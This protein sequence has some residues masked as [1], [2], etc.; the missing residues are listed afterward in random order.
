MNQFKTFL[1]LTAMTLILIYV[2]SLIGG[3]N[4]M[5]I[6]LGIAIV[7]NF[8][9]FF[10]SDKIVLAMY[11]ARPVD[12]NDNYILPIVRNLTNSANLPMPKVYII[13]EASPNAFATGR[14][15]HHAA[16]AVTT[17]ILNLLSK[18]ELEGVIAHELSHVK[19]RDILVSS[20][21]A[22]LVGTISII[23]RIAFFFGGGRDD[24]NGAGCIGNLIFI[25]LSSI[26]MFLIQMWISRTREYMADE[27]G[28]K[29]CGKP[30]ALASALDRLRTG[31]AARP[32][33][34]ANPVTQNMFIVNPLNA[35]SIA[36]LMS[37]HPPLQDRINRLNAMNMHQN[38]FIR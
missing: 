36:T 38:S 32:M 22:V 13:N 2:G 3:K 6:G 30:W 34:D 7:T 28:A 1:L 5:F 9:S 11:G 33:Q 24:E 20:I 27:S 15:P 8:I 10:F 18:D 17:G 16:V 26:A 12:A 23:A 14:D 19:N 29:M 4:G 37:T 35:E 25:I 21:A 31:V